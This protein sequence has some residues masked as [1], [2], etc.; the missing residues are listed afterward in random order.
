LQEIVLLFNPVV[1]AAR[2]QQGEIPVLVFRG[3]EV[4]D[5][6]RRYAPAEFV[7]QEP[8]NISQRVLYLTL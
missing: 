6:E 5:I 3:D 4:I 2:L 1:V 8:G 7:A